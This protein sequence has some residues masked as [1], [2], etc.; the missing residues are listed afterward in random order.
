MGGNGGNGW[1]YGGWDGGSETIR[2]LGTAWTGCFWVVGRAW[3]CARWVFAQ[4]FLFPFFVVL[5]FRGW[6]SLGSLGARLGQGGGSYGGFLSS[7]LEMGSCVEW[8]SRADSMCLN[9]YVWM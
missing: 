4:G 7:S 3:L 2:S 9:K 1:E 8:Q 5:M 6:G